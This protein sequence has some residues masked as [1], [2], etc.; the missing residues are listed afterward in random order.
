MARRA[1]S[2][3]D[4]ACSF[5]APGA[6]TSRQDPT[7]CSRGSSPARRQAATRASEGITDTTRAK[8]PFELIPFRSMTSSTSADGPTPL[9]SGAAALLLAHPSES[10][11]YLPHIHEPNYRLVP[12]HGR[13]QEVDARR[14]TPAL[15]T[16]AIPHHLMPAR[17]QGSRH[18]G[19]HES[20]GNI[21]HAHIHRLALRATDRQDEVGGLGERIRSREHS[22]DA[23]RRARGKPDPASLHGLGRRTYRADPNPVIDPIEAGDQVAVLILDRRV[24]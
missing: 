10:R 4:P 12:T 18:D 21:K 9:W 1:C 7:E 23:T 6:P 16:V 24:G 11:E 5:G 15:F 8:P 14:H 19:P 17:W 13:V 3:H 2:Y 22:E 20:P